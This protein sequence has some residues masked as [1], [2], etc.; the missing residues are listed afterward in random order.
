MVK[1]LW[2]GVVV[3]AVALVGCEPKG[4][5]ASP[6]A[7]VER[8]P[9]PE[10]PPSDPADL[11]GTW[12]LVEMGGQEAL[13]GT[14]LSFDS[15]VIRGSAICNTYNV[16]YTLSSDGQ[17]VLGQDGGL[18]EIA[19]VG[20]PPGWYEQE[21]GYW[22]QL[23]G[24]QAHRRDG[25]RLILSTAQGELVFV[26]EGSVATLPLEGTQ[27]QAYSLYQGGGE[28]TIATPQPVHLTFAEGQA[29]GSL[30]CNHLSGT[31]TLEG[32]SLKL[33]ELSLTERSCGSE[34]DA[35]EAQLWSFL[36]ALKDTRV[37]YDRMWMNSNDNDALYFCAAPAAP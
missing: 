6:P 34:A 5:K 2:I 4:D 32:E 16:S 26:P 24:L 36:R 33:G 20:L 17:L 14:T 8:A 3:V 23:N 7:K 12:H 37:K 22:R 10:A 31:Y 11:E 1:H 30:G 29:T 35:L 25:E 21:I 13:P 15:G 28:S 9:T 19:C 27:W 18:T